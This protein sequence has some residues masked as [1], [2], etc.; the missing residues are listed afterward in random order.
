MKIT[1]RPTTEQELREARQLAAL[2]QNHFIQLD[3]HP[4]VLEAANDKP[5]P[6]PFE[7]NPHIIIFKP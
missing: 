7:Y 1:L 4:L 2:M 6:L 3:H 5:P